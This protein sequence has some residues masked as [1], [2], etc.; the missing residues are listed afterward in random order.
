MVRLGWEVGD[1]CSLRVRIYM[2]I[3]MELEVFV[4][5]MM[6]LLGG[7]GCTVGKPRALVEWVVGVPDVIVVVY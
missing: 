7:R 1:D 6:V 4:S 2:M 5:L 3:V